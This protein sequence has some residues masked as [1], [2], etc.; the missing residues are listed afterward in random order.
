MT[1]A[2]RL[3]IMFYFFSLDNESIIVMSEDKG[4]ETQILNVNFSTFNYSSLG[5]RRYY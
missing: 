2:T 1:R 3:D 4:P 5:I